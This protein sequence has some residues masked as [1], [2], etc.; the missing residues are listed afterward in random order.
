MNLI[1]TILAPT[2]P[3][4]ELGILHPGNWPNDAV[5]G[6]S[7][8]CVD[9]QFDVSANRETNVEYFDSEE[10]YQEWYQHKADWIEGTDYDF[11]IDGGLYKW[12]W[13]PVQVG[14][15]YL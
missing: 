5:L 7:Y 10:A 12:D 1:D 8:L 14:I 3:N 15:V 4:K 11:S 9:K 6:V 2:I 13:G